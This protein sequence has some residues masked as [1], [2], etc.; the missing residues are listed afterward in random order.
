[1]LTPTYFRLNVGYRARHVTAILYLN[2]ANWDPAVDGGCLRLFL[3]AATTDRDGH[4]ATEIVDIS[5]IGGRLVLFDSQTVLHEVRHA[6]R[7]RC[8]ITVWFTIEDM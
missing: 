8:A 5:P 4:S 6:H 2:E 1:M 3:G 7:D